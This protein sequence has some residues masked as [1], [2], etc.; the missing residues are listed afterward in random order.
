MWSPLLCGMLSFMSIVAAAGQGRTAEASGCSKV[1]MDGELTAG[2]EWNA[3]LGQGWVFRIVPIDAGKT[4][5]GNYPYS[6]WDLVVDRTEGAGFP[7]ALL[8]ATLPYNSINEREVGTTFGLRAQDAIGWNPRSFRFLTDPVAFKEAQRSYRIVEA[9][10]GKSHDVGDTPAQ[11][12]ATERLLELEKRSAQG[13]FR[14]LDA[15]LTPGVADPAAYA[16][17]WA[18]AAQRTAHT[19]EPS[20][21]GKATPRGSLNWIRFS[22]VLWL[23]RK[24]AAPTGLHAMPSTC[25]Q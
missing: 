23:P 10:R 12:R 1:V 11:R 2:K 24:W 13:E 14:I 15:R 18:L 3:A 19:I 5:P 9:Q 21:R 25:S 20:A 17:N 7:D 4:Q 16:Q 8:L 22:L 6:G